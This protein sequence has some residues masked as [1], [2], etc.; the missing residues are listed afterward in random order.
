MRFDIK[1]YSL[2]PLIIIH[3]HKLNKMSS[4][5]FRKQ[6]PTQTQHPKPGN[7]KSPPPNTRTRSVSG[8]RQ[9]NNNDDFNKSQTDKNQIRNQNKLKFD[10]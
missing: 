5:S 1:Y 7:S 10:S 2:S 6:L 4:K 3:Q 9:L 8:S